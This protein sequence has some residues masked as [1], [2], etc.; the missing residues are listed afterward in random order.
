MKPDRPIRWGI[1][2]TGSIAAAFAT[3]LARLPDADLVAVGSRT[4]RGADAFG[5]RFAVPHRHASYADLVADDDVDVVYV[6]TPHPWH[7]PHALLA[8][9][10]GRAVLVEKPFTVNGSEAR[11]VIAAARSRG[12]FLME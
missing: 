7:H 6:A 5:D 1:I 8:I 9:A 11:E 4:R 10:A 3:D 2:G 12:T